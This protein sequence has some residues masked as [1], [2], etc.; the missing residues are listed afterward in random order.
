MNAPILTH[1][2]FAINENEQLLT[3]N[4]CKRWVYV[5]MIRQRLGAGVLGG[6]VWGLLVS[7]SIRKPTL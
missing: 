7:G 5:D 2:F 4:Q 1:N 3:V 6:G